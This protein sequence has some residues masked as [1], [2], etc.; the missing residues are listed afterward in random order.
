[1][2]GNFVNI[3]KFENILRN[4]VNILTN[5]S[6]YSQISQK[7][8]NF[9]KYSQISQNINKISQIHLGMITR[10]IFLQLS[11]SVIG[12]FVNIEKFKNF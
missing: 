1:M 9:S 6:K 2:I 5:F 4:F 12:N 8:S 11:Y 3:E 7:F 10:F